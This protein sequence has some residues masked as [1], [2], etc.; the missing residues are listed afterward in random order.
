MN[1]S[2]KVLGTPIGGVSDVDG[3][4]DGFV[5]GPS[6]EDNI[7]APLTNLPEELTTEMLKKMQGQV[8][9]RYLDKDK[10]PQKN[11]GDFMMSAEEIMKL[12]AENYHNQPLL[13]PDTAEY[14]EDQRR[15]NANGMNQRVRKEGVFYPIILRKWKDG[16]ITIFDGHH[17]LIAAYDNHPKFQVPYFLW[18][19]E[20][21]IEDEFTNFKPESVQEIDVPDD[22]HNNKQDLTNRKKNFPNLKFRRSGKSGLFRLSTG[23]DEEGTPYEKFA[24]LKLAGQYLKRAWAHDGLVSDSKYSDDLRQAMDI[25]RNGFDASRGMA[26]VIAGE[27]VPDLSEQYRRQAVALR[28]ALA[29]APQIGMPAYRVAWITPEVGSSAEVGAELNF[30]AGAV[31]FKPEIAMA[32]DRGELEGS[33]VGA[34]LGEKL[35]FEFPSTARGLIYDDSNHERLKQEFHD[36]P[37]EAIVSGKFRVA[38]IEEREIL[39]PYSQK[40]VKRKVH[41]LESVNND[42]APQATETPVKRDKTVS[43]VLVPTEKFADARRTGRPWLPLTQGGWAPELRQILDEQTEYEKELAKILVPWFE[44]TKDEDRSTD[45]VGYTLHS[46]RL[47]FQGSDVFGDYEYLEGQFNSLPDNLRKSK[48]AKAL[49]DF[50]K[51]NGVPAKSRRSAWSRWGDLYVDHVLESLKKENVPETNPFYK[52]MKYQKDTGVSNEFGKFMRKRMEGMENYGILLQAMAD[53]RKGNETV[54]AQ[55]VAEKVVSNPDRRI[56]LNIKERVLLDLLDGGSLKN[57]FENNGR[58]AFINTWLIDRNDRQEK[59]RI[60]NQMLYRQVADQMIFGI[61]GAGNKKE[62]HPLSAFFHPNGVQDV[63]GWGEAYGQISLVMKRD[64]ESR[65]TM[66]AG[67]S[68]AG[69]FMGASPLNDPQAVGVQGGWGGLVNQELP[70]FENAWINKYYEAQIFGGVDLSDIAYV[71][72]P[73]GFKFENEGMIEQLQS[74]GLSVIEIP[75]SG[76]VAEPSELKVK[77]DEVMNA[78]L[79]ASYDGVRLFTTGEDTGFIVLENGK[80]VDIQSV[81][82]VLKFGNWIF[83]ESIKEKSLAKRT[84]RRNN[85]IRRTHVLDRSIQAEAKAL[86]LRT[87]Q[88]VHDYYE[89]MSNATEEK[90]DSP[91]TNP[92]LRER[93]KDRVMAGS[94][95]GRPGQWSAR[96][97]QLVAQRYRSAGGGYKKGRGKTKKQRSLSKWTKEKWRTSDGKPALRGG[98]MRRYL[99]DKVWGKLTPSQR[100]ATNRKKIEGD[101]RGRQFVP[102]TETAAS[103]AA[104][105]RKRAK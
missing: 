74:R 28:Y 58:N 13:D 51:K 68:L 91:Y 41:V 76:F 30:G 50:A 5:T 98:K 92:A 1:D 14:L 57:I 11:D 49:L 44:K 63:K 22:L 42:D 26:R 35:M 32:Y 36:N 16:K 70:E 104:K 52:Q 8:D 97:A 31:G 81:S 87:K 7:P 55:S 60:T 100:A 102:N 47:A 64:V 94:Q 6:G 54:D 34:R 25:W 103:T 90:V 56:G 83:E 72:V 61:F 93:I 3:D 62:N 48:E 10:S 75:T 95:G 24:R 38:K 33:T 65:A 19:E 21:N 40:K 59:D 67:D 15:K 85:F 96:K 86:Q 80:R 43:D 88:Y 9:P 4:G 69:K 20:G 53:I 73:Q 39:D 27:D 71:A 18:E 37:V 46:I 105:F 12:P 101:K 78:P 89:I 29:G 84:M 77:R 66:T 82:S 17:R 45:E 23:E 2:S 79:L 99:P